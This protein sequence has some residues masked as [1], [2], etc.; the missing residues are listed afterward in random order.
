MFKKL[1]AKNGESLGEVLAGLLVVSLAV[2]M[3]CGAV[4][5]S[6]R[7]EA[8]TRTTELFAGGTPDSSETKQVKVDGANYMNVTVYDDGGLYYY[9]KT[10]P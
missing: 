2:L 4:I 5:A 1:T 10:T 9:E 7:L 8:A 6:A 3:L